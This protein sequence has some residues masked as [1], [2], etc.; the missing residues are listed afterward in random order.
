MK[1]LRRFPQ[2][3]A[4]L[5]DGRLNLTTLEIAGKVMTPE[6][7]EA[8]VL[9]FA[10]LTKRKSEELL[11][12]IQEK[13][14]RL[15]SLLSHKIPDGNLDAGPPT[16]GRRAPIPP[17][18][19][20]EVMERD[21]YRCTYVSPDGRRCESTWRLELHH[22][23]PAPM[24]GS[25][26]ADDLTVRCRPHNQLHAWEDWGR[27]HVERRTRERRRKSRATSMINDIRSAVHG[28]HDPRPR[29]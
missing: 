21:G 20:R 9:Q 27:E 16:P 29:P 15:R 28:E 10:N 11:V 14:R 18:V 3:E 19:R 4:P 23:E 17:A 1:L 26:T 13:L 2:L 25:S 22:H 12:S 6:N 7:V 24:T 8:L 5:A